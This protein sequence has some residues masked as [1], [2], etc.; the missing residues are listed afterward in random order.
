LR[1][2]SRLRA[3]NVEGFALVDSAGK[4]I[5]FAWTTAFEGFFL[6][7]LNAKVE[8]PSPEA[9][10][11]FDCWTPVAARGRGYYGHAIELLA[12]KVRRAGKQPWIFSAARNDASARGIEKAGFQR[13]YSL[14]RQK[15]FN[16][17]RVKGRPPLAQEGPP[18]EVSARV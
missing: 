2:A 4:P 5:H 6:A 17:Q 7:E 15:A 11:L 16:L 10:L 3:G 14:I 1:S 12:D 18:A 13:R 9:V 8:A